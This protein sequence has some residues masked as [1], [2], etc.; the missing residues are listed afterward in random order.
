[1]T[2]R[3]AVLCALPPYKYRHNK[4]FIE[5]YKKATAAAATAG[6]QLQQQTKQTKVSYFKIA[7][8]TRPWGRCR[9]LLAAPPV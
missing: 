5:A 9:R 3:H 6:Q 8:L 4:I 7:P 1:M 2:P